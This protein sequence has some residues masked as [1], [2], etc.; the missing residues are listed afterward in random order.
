MLQGTLAEGE[1]SVHMT[2]SFRHYLFVK[3]SIRFSISKAADLD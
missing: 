2:P 1:G 3:K